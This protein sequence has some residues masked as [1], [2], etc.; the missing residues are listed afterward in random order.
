METMELMNALE[1]RYAV[2]RFAED[3]LEEAEVRALL[4]A[5]RL[6]A[7][8]YG[9]QPYRILVIRDAELRRR[10]VDHSY[11]QDKVAESSHLLVLAARTD[12]GDG[13]VDEHIARMAAARDAEAASLEPLAAHIKEY[14][15]GRTAEANL[16]WAHEQT[17]VALGNLLT[18]AALL[19]IDACPMGGFDARAWDR[20]L[21]L[22]A[23]HLATSVLCAIG[24]RHAED[25]AAT[26]PKVRR[27][28]D[29]FVEVHA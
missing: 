28:W 18:S 5:T 11:G 17:H 21:G 6:S 22:S 13:L 10:L 3:R 26:A 9:L 14:F 27:A 20:E 4:E 19:G 2:R 12:V 16:R 8:S 25:A 7:S 1:W 29:D 23:R 15:A 24:R